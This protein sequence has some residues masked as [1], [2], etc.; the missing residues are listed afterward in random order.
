MV[1]HDWWVSI[2][3]VLVRNCFLRGLISV[4]WSFWEFQFCYS[5]WWYQGKVLCGWLPCPFRTLPVWVS[6]NKLYLVPKQAVASFGNSSPKEAEIQQCGPTF[7]SVHFLSSLAACLWHHS[8]QCETGG[9]S[10]D[11]FVFIKS[12]RNICSRFV[13]VPTNCWSNLS[14]RPSLGSKRKKGEKWKGGGRRGKRRGS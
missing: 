9:K 3:V 8:I 4:V 13:T 10:K 11:S 5:C 2:L 1:G 12:K 6:I 7:W 14:I